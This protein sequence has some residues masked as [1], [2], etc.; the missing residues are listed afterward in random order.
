M[1]LILLALALPVCATVA[2]LDKAG[3]SRGVMMWAARPRDLSLAEP[4]LEVACEASGAN[5]NRRFIR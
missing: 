5:S 1:A 3:R 2:S 4:D